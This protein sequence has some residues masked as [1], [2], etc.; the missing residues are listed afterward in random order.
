MTRLEE[1][2]EE[3][4]KL[5]PED[6]HEIRSKII[7]L[8]DDEWLD[9]DDDP[10]TPAQTAMLDRRIAEHERDPGSA[11]PWEDFKRKVLERLKEQKPENFDVNQEG[12]AGQ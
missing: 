2:L 1:I 6:R 10:L 8:D 4:P 3:L 7:E 5:S 9:D 11:I 12:I